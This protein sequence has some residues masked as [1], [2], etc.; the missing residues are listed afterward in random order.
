MIVGAG[1]SNGLVNRP[2]C[3]CVTPSFSADLD[4][5]LDSGAARNAPEPAMKA[6]VASWLGSTAPWDDMLS[7]AVVRPP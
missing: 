7:S 2:P 3:E 1:L 6:A 4:T 5:V